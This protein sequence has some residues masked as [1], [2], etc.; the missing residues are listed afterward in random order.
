MPRCGKSHALSECVTRLELGTSSNERLTGFVGRVLLEVLDETTCEILSLGFPFGS[1]CV[2]VA[3]IEDF[4]SNAREFRGDLEVED[5]E[6]L[7]GSREDSTGKDT[8]DDTTSVLNGDALARTIPSRVH[9]ISLGTALFHLLHEFSSVLR[10]VEFEE[11]LTE[12][13]RESGSGF[14]DTTFRTGELSGKAA[15]EVVLRLTCVEDR[16]GRQYAEGISREEDHVLSGGSSRDGA[17][18]ALDV[19]D[20]V[21]NAGVLCCTVVL[22]RMIH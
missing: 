10:R 7:R 14:R 15:E 5:G 21:G 20:G 3:G 18:D 2:S 8:V 17:N 11:G 12:A 9:E 4:G 16:N 6:L 1:V 19:G 13:S 22:L